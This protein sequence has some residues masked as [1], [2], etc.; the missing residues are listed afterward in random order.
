VGLYV[1]SFG[2][3][4]SQGHARAQ[5]CFQADGDDFEFLC[6]LAQG[7]VLAYAGRTD[8]EDA[9][10]YVDATTLDALQYVPMPSCFRMSGFHSQSVAFPQMMVVDD[11]VQVMAYESGGGC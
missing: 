4:A 9:L 5:G 10:R 2:R 6:K 3:E 1:P 8:N 11:V 7:L